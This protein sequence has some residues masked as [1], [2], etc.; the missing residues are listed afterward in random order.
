MGTYI[1]AYFNGI[2]LCREIYSMVLGQG[3]MCD[4]D[5]SIRLQRIGKSDLEAC[6]RKS[7]AVAEISKSSSTKCGGHQSH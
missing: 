7:G 4:H 5:A 6:G 3:C 1:N 2:L